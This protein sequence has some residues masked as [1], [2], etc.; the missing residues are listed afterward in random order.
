MMHYL[1]HM[2]DNFVI[3]KDFVY[4]VLLEENISKHQNI[5]SWAHL[6]NFAMCSLMWYIYEMKHCAFKKINVT[7][8]MDSY[9]II[10]FFILI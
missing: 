1:Q 4:E 3:F 5:S 10:E 2:L 7:W 9:N 6:F 8:Y